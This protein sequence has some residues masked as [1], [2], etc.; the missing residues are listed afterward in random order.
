[1][2]SR[3]WGDWET[4]EDWGQGIRDIKRRVRLPHSE[5]L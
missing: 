5:D 2:R 4:V 3:E 1:M